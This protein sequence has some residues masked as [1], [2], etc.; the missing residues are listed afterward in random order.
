MRTVWHP[1]VFH[2]GYF[3][4]TKKKKKENLLGRA[5][6]KVTRLLTRFWCLPSGPRARPAHDSTTQDPLFTTPNTHRQAE[7]HWSAVHDVKPGPGVRREW[8]WSAVF[9]VHFKGFCASTVQDLV[10]N[11]LKHQEAN[12]FFSARSARLEGGHDLIRKIIKAHLGIFKI[13]KT[14]F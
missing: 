2:S 7:S 5:L 1:R 13:K 9:N 11:G 12:K 8:R 4:T 6:V 14:I 3:S 10:I